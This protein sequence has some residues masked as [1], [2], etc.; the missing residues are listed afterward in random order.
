MD[1]TKNYLSSLDND[2]KSN[3]NNNNEQQFYQQ[4]RN[5]LTYTPNNNENNNNNNNNDNNS[6][7]YSNDNTTLT[8]REYADAD[9]PSD[10]EL[11][12]GINNS[13]KEIEETVTLIGKSTDVI[14]DKGDNESL[15]INVKEKEIVATIIE[16]HKKPHGM[17]YDGR[18]NYILMVDALI[19][20][21]FAPIVYFTYYIPNTT[22][23]PF[24][25][26]VSGS[27]SIPKEDTNEFWKYW[28]YNIAWSKYAL[29]MIC[30]VCGF[31]YVSM[32]TE[33]RSVPFH[34][35]YKRHRDFFQLL[36]V[37]TIWFAIGGPSRAL[38]GK[39]DVIIGLD[40]H[41]TKNTTHGFSAEESFFYNYFGF[42]IPFLLGLHF[43]YLDRN[44]FLRSAGDKFGTPSLWRTFK[45]LEI[46]ALCPIILFILTMAAIHIYLIIEDHLW[47]YFAIAYGL[48]F[49]IMIG[50]SWL[51]RSTYYLHIHHYFMFGCMIPLT[52]F[53]TILSLISLGAVSGIAVEGVSRWS[54]GFLWYRGERVL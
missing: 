15:I 30:I 52:G 54:M 43:T 27:N 19:A 21:V 35:R 50:V 44:L 37:G 47:E 4:R 23:S 38:L 33:K 28:Y 7:L 3:N 13:P 8:Q 51:I 49:F 31:A 16:H 11:E 45:P 39:N 10:E 53:Q 5:S 41:I 36:F 2:N 25:S 32:I 18:K 29:W 22:F 40:D 17:C 1:N 20:I 46:I 42:F 34:C 12:D 6:I 9:Y 14:I 48:F 26:G 24:E